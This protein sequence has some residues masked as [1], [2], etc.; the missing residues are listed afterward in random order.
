MKPLH[1]YSRSCSQAA[2]NPCAPPE[3]PT[4]SWR[5]RIINKQKI[6]TATHYYG[7]PTLILFWFPMILSVFHLVAAP[8][9]CALRVSA[10]KWAARKESPL[11]QELRTPSGF[12]ISAFGFPSGLGFRVSGFRLRRAAD[13]CDSLRPHLVHNELHLLRLP[14]YGLGFLLGPKLARAY[15]GLLTA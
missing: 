7:Q 12:R 4:E 9:G 11:A 14:D 13:L 5:D 3:G 1:C 10:V 6:H 15:C 2:R 8:P